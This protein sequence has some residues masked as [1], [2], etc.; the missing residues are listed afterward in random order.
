MTDTISG[1]RAGPPGLDRLLEKL[2]RG[3]VLTVR[4]GPARPIR[5]ASGRPCGG[6][7]CAVAQPDRWIGHDDDVGSTHDHPGQHDVIGH[8]HE[9]GESERAI[10]SSVGRSW[11]TVRWVIQGEIASMVKF[12]DTERD[13]LAPAPADVRPQ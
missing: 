3:D 2:Q 6:A 1:S 7:G 9:Q 13:G 12:A 11:L 4:H 10:A 8:L 5:V